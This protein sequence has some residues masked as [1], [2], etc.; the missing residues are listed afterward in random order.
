MGNVK[1]IEILLVED[2]AVDAEFAVRALKKNHLANK[3]VHLK[4]GEEALD[5][6]FSTITDRIPRLIL[7]DLN[8]PKMGGLEFIQKIKSDEQTKNIPIVVLTSSIQFSSIKESVQLAGGMYIS[9]PV[10]FDDIA[11]ILVE[12]NYSFSIIKQDEK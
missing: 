1:E 9:K 7:L 6:I 3:M 10:D 11:S 4:D 12:L 5:Y 2:D 8:M